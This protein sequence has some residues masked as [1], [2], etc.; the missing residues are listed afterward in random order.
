MGRAPGLST[1]DLGLAWAERP[2]WLRPWA[3]TLCTL[4]STIVKSGL[5]FVAPDAF[6]FTPR[7]SRL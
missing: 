1:G 3:L 2:G 4:P 6:H 7:L 5:H